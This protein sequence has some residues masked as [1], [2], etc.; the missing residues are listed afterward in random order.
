MYLRENYRG[1]TITSLL[2]KLLEQV[3]II[4]FE[5]TLPHSHQQFGFTKNLSPNMAAVCVSEAIAQASSKNPLI[6]VSLDA[7]K[8][9]DRV[10]HS[11]LLEK[12]AHTQIP[13][14][15]WATVQSLYDTPRRWWC[16]KTSRAA[17]TQSTSGSGKER[18]CPHLSTNCTYMTS[19]PR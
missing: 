2:G 13:F 14:S 11:I 9:F 1:I 19:S 7:E 4:K 8:A 6:V 12:L 10:D 5:H 15:V 17:S 18:Y 3:I 16:A